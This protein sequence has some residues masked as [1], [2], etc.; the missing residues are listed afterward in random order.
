VEASFKRTGLVRRGGQI[1]LE[2]ASAEISRVEA[3]I[4]LLRKQFGDCRPVAQSKGTVVTRYI[5]EGELAAAGQPLVQIARLDTV[6]V[7]IYL[8]PADLS[9]IQLN[10]RAEVDPEDG[11]ATPLAGS[12]TW[13]SEKAEFTPKNVQTKEARADLVYAVK[14][15]IPN[16]DGALKIGMPVLIT[17]P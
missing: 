16:S 11:R 3:D 2:G 8:P 1:A 12:V 14:I 5:D 13:I 9:R 6:W 4:A 15:R 17:I 7:K 10:A